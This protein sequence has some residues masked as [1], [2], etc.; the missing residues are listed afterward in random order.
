MSSPMRLRR[1]GLDTE[2]LITH[3][4]ERVAFEP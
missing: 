3:P 4:G 1:S 2:V